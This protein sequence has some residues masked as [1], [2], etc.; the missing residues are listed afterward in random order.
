ML[1]EDYDENEI[2]LKPL[3]IDG[4]FESF[5][6]CTYPGVLSTKYFIGSC[7]SI[8]NCYSDIY[9]SARLNGAGYLQVHMSTPENL[10]PIKDFMVHRLVAWEWV[11]LNRDLFLDVNHRDGNKLNNFCSNLEWVTHLDNVRYAFKNNLVGCCKGEH[12]RHKLTEIQVREICSRLED[13][14]VSFQQIIDEMKLDVSKLSISSIA[15]GYNWSHITKD[16][17]I[18]PRTKDPYKNTRRL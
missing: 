15:N 4:Y 9:L 12:H 17:N 16:Y 13:P 6:Q 11:L 10:R 7:G 18:P 2:I 8:Y 14:N 3:C 5:R 1:Y